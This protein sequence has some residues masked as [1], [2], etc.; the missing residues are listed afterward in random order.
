MLKNK[1]QHDLDVRDVAP[2]IE[3]AIRRLPNG[4]LRLSVS[5]FPLSHVCLAGFCAPDI[6][7]RISSDYSMPSANEEIAKQFYEE[8]TMIEKIMEE[9]NIANRPE[10]QALNRKAYAIQMWDCYAIPWRFHNE[11]VH[12]IWSPHDLMGS[13]IIHSYPVSCFLRALAEILEKHYNQAWKQARH[14]K[15]WRIFAILV[16][17]IIGFVLWAIIGKSLV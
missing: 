3:E 4:D 7:Q 2:V 17:I 14:L 13:P 15:Y 9:M 11:T 10:L 12:L 5:R 1:K 6:S 16:L 8:I